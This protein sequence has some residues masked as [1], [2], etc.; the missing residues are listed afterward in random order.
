LEQ[1]LNAF[2]EPTGVVSE[3]EDDESAAR[4]VAVDLRAEEAKGS[5]TS[6]TSTSVASKTIQAPIDHQ[7]PLISIE[8]AMCRLGP[9]VL[10][11][12]EAKFK[13]SFTQVRHPDEND[14][15]FR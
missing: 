7:S 14:L 5:F 4:D 1:S 10:A 12:L 2:V 11:T 13:G 3:H 6:E 8:D 9:K 15:F